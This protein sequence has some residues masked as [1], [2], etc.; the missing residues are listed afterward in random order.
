MMRQLVIAFAKL[1]LRDFTVPLEQAFA[2]HSAQRRL[3]LTSAPHVLEEPLVR[4]R[5]RPDKQPLVPHALQAQVPRQL[6]LPRLRRV[7]NVQSANTV[8]GKRISA[9]RAPLT[10]VL[11]PLVASTLPHALRAQ[12]APFR[13]QAQACA[14]HLANTLLQEPPSA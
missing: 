14:V 2:A 6:A 1:A 12:V 3:A 11:A 13:P 5:H 9:P 10:R 7:F 8:L 4:L